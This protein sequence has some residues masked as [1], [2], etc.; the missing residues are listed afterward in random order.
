[1][2]KEQIEILKFYET[3]TAETGEDDLNSVINAVLA[4]TEERKT[5]KWIVWKDC[6]GK[7]RELTCSE[8][9]CQRRT[10]VNPN[11]CEDCGAKME[12][13]DADSN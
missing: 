5:G 9:G 8:C 6:E 4:E 1:M 12:V 10:W 11:Y 13:D 2:T 7:T 3:V